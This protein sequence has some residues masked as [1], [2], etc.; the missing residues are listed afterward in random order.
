[1]NILS[2]L[3]IKNVNRLI[4]AHININ[5]I[6]NKFELLAQNIATNIDIL[7]ISETKIDESFLIGQFLI[8]G[9]STPYRLDRN[10]KGGGI[11]VYVREGIPSKLI[12][13]SKS[14]EGMFIEINIRKKNWLICYSYNPNDTRW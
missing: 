4:V 3:R 8:K 5:S 11:L 6:R 2:K 7:M 13:T 14:I 10:D 12:L 9:F 1:M